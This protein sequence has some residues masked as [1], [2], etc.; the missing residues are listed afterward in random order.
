MNPYSERVLSRRTF[1]GASAAALATTALAAEGL[2][3]AGKSRYQIVGF[4]KPFQKLPFDQIADIAREAGWD[5]IECPVRRNGAI[6]PGDVEEKL[7]ALAEALRKREL[8]MPVLAT[9]VEEADDRLAQKVLKTASKLGIKR[10]RLKHY[11]YDL[12]KPIPPQLKEFG[13][14]LRDLAR[15]NAELGLQGAVQNHSGSR[16]VGAP[17]WDLWEMMREFDPKAMGIFFDIGHAT[18]EGG[19]AWPIHAKLAEPLL[20]VVSVKD[21]VWAKNQKGDWRADW[22][23]LGDGMVRPQ[24]FE[25][26]KKSEFNGPLSIHFEYQMGEG[27]EMIAAM[28]K[29]AAVLRRWIGA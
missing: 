15:L 12:Q 1:I 16:Y 13:A 28:K 11:Y 5:G 9:D 27:K 6:E 22:C 25:T 7:P 23:P 21:F 10:Y 17:I 26:L 18:V 8:T 4:I 2:S 14:K 19:Y 3:G 24:F 29:D 20:S